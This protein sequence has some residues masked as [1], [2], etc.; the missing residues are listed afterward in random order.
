LCLC[1]C[2]VYMFLTSIESMRQS[3]SLWNKV[4]KAFLS[5]HYLH[6]VILKLRAATS[7][8][9]LR[10][11]ASR[12][13]SDLRN[14][15]SVRHSWELNFPVVLREHDS[16]ESMSAA[17]RLMS[18]LSCS[19]SRRALWRY[20]TS[21][22]RTGHRVLFTSRIIF[23]SSQNI[24]WKYFFSVSN[25]IVVIEAPNQCHFINKCRLEILLVVK[26]RFI[27]TSMSF[28]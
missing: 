7:R 24:P 17:L 8:D 12:S 6:F 4:I 2:L 23:D 28:D 14:D 25:A 9:E 21:E 13:V 18:S 1:T 19:K 20:G 10:R 27:V 11:A 15:F 5:Y 3:V 26:F 16:S 22:R